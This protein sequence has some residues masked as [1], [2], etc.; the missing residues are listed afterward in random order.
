MGKPRIPF[1]FEDV[2]TKPEMSPQPLISDDIQQ[3]LATLGGYDG[4]T[5]RLLRCTKSG[6]LQTVNPLAAEFVNIPATEANFI[7]QGDNIKCT[8][9]VVRAHP[10]NADRVWVNI[11]AAAAADTG[12]P[13]D[14]NEYV[15][16]TVNNLEHIHL[17][18]IANNEKVILLYT[19]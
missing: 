16:L 10:D 15:T 1:G 4:E 12:W 5:R 3:V 2:P 11:F 9:V 7:W 13:L 14:K 18:I 19:Q 6:K 8:E 17:K